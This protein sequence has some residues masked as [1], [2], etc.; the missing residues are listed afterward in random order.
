MFKIKKPIAFFFGGLALGLAFGFMRY[1]NHWVYFPI[2]P[3]ILD[4]FVMIAIGIYLFVESLKS[5][6][7]QKDNI[8]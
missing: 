6:S 1:F 4:S 3:N 5:P 8:T 7:V 2:F